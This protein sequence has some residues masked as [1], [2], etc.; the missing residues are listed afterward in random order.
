MKKLQLSSIITPEVQ[1]DEQ[2][3]A[4]KVRAKDFNGLMDPII[5]FDH[6]ELT[7]DIFGPHPH[8]GMSALSYVFEDSAPYQSIDSLGNNVT[9]TPGSLLWTW[10]GRGVV[11]SEYPVP[12]GASVEGLQLF[13]NIPANKK[14][15]APQSVFIDK[16]A[17][18]EIIEDGIL[19]RVV[20]GSTNTV[21]NTIV[22]P[23]P[24][25]ILHAFIES[26]K[27]YK[28][29]LP[30][31]WSGTVFAVEGHFE[32]IINDQAIEL[33]EGNVLAMSQSDYAEPITFK[34]IGNSQLL[35]ISG[36][37]LKE[38]IFTQGAMAMENRD[39]LTAALADYN[40]G[41]M[42][43]IKIDGTTRIVVAPV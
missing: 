1:G 43:F 10:A 5:G 3:F 39:A 41:K 25:T 33:E 34:G 12:E 22:T 35:F 15:L 6:F 13:V 11:H 19:V 2:F 37:P 23:E 8:A 17:M 30:A 28:H 4:R 24:L 42:G 40:A 20:C 9:V 32:I 36:K 31:G 18:P 16:N 21:V 7:K 27:E 29:T 14:H 26:E 38:E